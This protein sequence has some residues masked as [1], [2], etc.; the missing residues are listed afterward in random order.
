MEAT[1]ASGET[2][3]FSWVVLLA[4]IRLSTKAGLFPRPLDLDSAVDVVRAWTTAPGAVIVEPTLQ[5]L[6]TVAGLLRPAGT[7]GN[8]TND[9]HLAALA[10]EHRGTLVSFDRDFLRFADLR[11]EL[12]S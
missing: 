2:V 10:M 8:L 5:H 3:A 6:E 12:L 7:A 11:F 1:L 4:F 9:A